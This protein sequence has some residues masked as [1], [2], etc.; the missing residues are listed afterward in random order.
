MAV[1]QVAPPQTG[2]DPLSDVGAGPLA[3]ASQGRHIKARSQPFVP[4]PAG[5]TAGRVTLMLLYARPE[6]AA[7]IVHCA[8]EM[9]GVDHQL[10]YVDGAADSSISP[11]DYLKI[12]PRGTVP[13][14]IDGEL[15]I[16]ETV[17]ILEYL[18]ETQPGLGPRSGEVGRPQLHFWLG[19][20]TNNLMAALYRWFHPERMISADAA[21][22]LRAG[23]IANLT[24]H[25][26][27]LEDELRSRQWLVGDAPS[28]ADVYLERLGSW[29]EEIDGLTFGGGALAGHASRTSALPGV[30]A[31]LAQEAAVRLG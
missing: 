31:A 8:L 28:V 23:A 21:S 16:Y 4:T 27:W 15:T 2:S 20:L 10:A 6:S 24:A 26:S 22:A 12:N 18:V 11:A 14:L 13:T 1:T 3:G 30:A 19:W 17:A 5:P 29:T 7:T 25:G 9:S